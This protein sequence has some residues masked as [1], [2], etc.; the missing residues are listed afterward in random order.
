LRDFWFKL[1]RDVPE[2]VLHDAQQHSVLAAPKLPAHLPP[3][4]ADEVPEGQG[5]YRL[6]DS[7]GTLLYVGRSNSLRAHV[8]AQ[9]GGRQTHA[10]TAP[11]AAQVH[12]I[13]WVQTSGELGAMLQEAAWLKVGR[14]TFNRGR[15]SSAESAT[16]RLAPDG[17]GRV[18]PQRIDALEPHDLAQCFGVFHSEKDALKA[19]RDIARARQLCLKVLG[20]EESPGSCFALQV[21]KC[22]GACVGKEPLILHRTRVQLALSSLK[23]KSWPYPGRIALRESGRA[24]PDGSFGG[25]MHVIDHWAYL[26]SA[27]SA[28]ELEA[29]RSTHLCA[30]FDVDVY[31]ILLRYFSNHPSPDWHDLRGSALSA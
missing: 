24:C 6:F 13:D 27:R 17:S 23:I 8:L 25:Q 3:H 16:L 31:K 21:G 1:R 9:L 26:G 11:L 30:E 10:G 7:A 18:E 4:W 29:L 2:T 5:A 15:K 20:L 14:P 22:K 12:R 19:L 28:D